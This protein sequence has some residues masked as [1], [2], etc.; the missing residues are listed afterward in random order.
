EPVEELDRRRARVRLLGRAA[1]EL[2]E[3]V[4]LLRPGGEDPARAVVFERPADQPHPVGDEGGGEG[5]TG[6]AL[7]LLAVPGEPERPGT[8]HEPAADPVGLGGARCLRRCRG[9]LARHLI[10]GHHLLT[11][12]VRPLSRATSRAS[13]TSVISCVS[14]LR[15]TTS[16]ERSPC[17]WYQSS[18]CSPAGLSRRWR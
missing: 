12:L 16:Q 4:R 8:V 6:M 10:A 14:V 13:A 5:I 1:A 7:E 9:M 2:D 11:H 3:R 17:S 18:L 15:V